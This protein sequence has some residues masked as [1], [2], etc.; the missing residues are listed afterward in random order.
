MVWMPDHLFYAMKNGGQGSKQSSGSGWIPDDLFYAMKIAQALEGGG[1]RQTFS[2]GS[3]KGKVK[4]TNWNKKTK[5]PTKVVTDTANVNTTKKYK[6]TC[7]TYAKLDGYGFI[8]PDQKG[9]VPGDELFVRFDE[10]KSTDRC[11]ML[12]KGM[13]VQFSLKTDTVRG[14][15]VVQAAKVTLP[16]GG[17]IAVQDD[18]DAETKTFVG[19]QFLRYIGNLKFYLDQKGYGYIEIDDGFDY[20]GEQVPKQIRVE[21]LEMNCGPGKPA[22]MMKEVPVEFGIWKKEKKGD[23]YLAY[24]VTAP[25]GELLPSKE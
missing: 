22:K 14:K 21:K 7:K 9:V 25:G 6:G 12:T 1:G 16:G 23:Q 13:K 18:V 10:I 15:Q 24:N 20:G 17:A 3:G 11:P 4:Q 19:G 5:P 2:K 8:I